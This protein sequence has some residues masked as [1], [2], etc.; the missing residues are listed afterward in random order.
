LRPFLKFVGTTP[1]QD[2]NLN[3][4]RVTANRNFTNK[5]WNAAKFILMNLE[6]V[7]DED[8]SHLAAADFSTQDSL[9]GLKLAD[10]WIISSLHQAPP[11]HTHT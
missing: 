11:P 5:L 9:S 4:E 8:W 1:G 2:L 10:A 7:S 6:E 3:L